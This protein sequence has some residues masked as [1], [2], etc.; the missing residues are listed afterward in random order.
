VPLETVTYGTNKRKDR[1]LY[2][3]QNG[4]KEDT[5]LKENNPG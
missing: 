4:D 3:M 1:V 2:A 5:R